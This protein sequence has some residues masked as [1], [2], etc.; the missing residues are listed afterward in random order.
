MNASTFLETAALNHFFRNQPQTPSAQLF[1]ALYISDPTDDN[2]GTE[3]Q[4]GGYARQQI[5][6]SAPVQV[7]AQVGT[8]G[9]IANNA[10]IRFPVAS[11]DWGVVSHFGILTAATGGN[12]LAHA[13]VPVPKII[14]SGDEA[15][16]NV[17]TLTISID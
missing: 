12:L 8:K 9:Q 13:P 5:A 10:E 11:T 14:E 2:V 7:P 1:V 3:I 17:G 16:F 4:G 6:F 15:K